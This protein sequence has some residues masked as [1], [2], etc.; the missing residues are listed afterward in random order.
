MEERSIADLQV[1]MQ[2]GQATAQR[3]AQAYLDHIAALDQN[4]PTLRAVIELN[5]DALAV[6]A[7]LDVERQTRG[8]RGPLHGIP[9]LL[10]TRP[11]HMR[12]MWDKSAVERACISELAVTHVGKGG[13]TRPQRGDALTR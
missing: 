8:P 7:S 10:W 3:L 12:H 6:A 11:L 2:M 5:P 4:G 1:Q 9:I 13:G